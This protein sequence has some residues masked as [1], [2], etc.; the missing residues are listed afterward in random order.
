MFI[1]NKKLKRLYT[2]IEKKRKER[3]AFIRYYEEKARKA[4]YADEIDY[5]DQQANDCAVAYDVL[6]EV[7]ALIKEADKGGL[8]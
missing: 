7:L 6:G 2:A 1:L 8:K 4:K 5:Y 3:D